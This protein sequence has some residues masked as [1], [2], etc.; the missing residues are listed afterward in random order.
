MQGWTIAEVKEL[1]EAPPR[2]HTL[3]LL[4][5]DIPQLRHLLQVVRRHPHLHDA[6]LIKVGITTID[7]GKGI[8]L[9]IKLQKVHPLEIWGMIVVV[10]TQHGLRT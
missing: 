4:D 6:L 5:L 10:L 7:E 9:A 8:G 1:V 3:V 2:R